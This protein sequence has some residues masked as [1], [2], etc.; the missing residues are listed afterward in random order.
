V[1]TADLIG[2]QLRP[3]DAYVYTG[4]ATLLDL[5]T[6]QEILADIADLSHQQRSAAIGQ[7][8]ES[9]EWV[10]GFTGEALRM[11]QRQQVTIGPDEPLKLLYV[12]N[13]RRAARR[14]ADAI[15][16]HM[17]DDFARLVVSDEPGALRTLRQATKER[18]PCAIVAVRMVTEGFDCPEV[19]TIAYASNWVAPLFVTQ[20]MARAM[21]ITATERAQKMILP[22]QFL[23]PDHAALRDAFAAALQPI[24]HVIKELEQI[25][26]P[27][28]DGI[29]GE[30][31]LPRFQLLD[32]S[33][34]ELR[35]ATVIGEADGDIPA[36]ELTEWE[37]ELGSLGVPLPFV[38][39]VA[40][41]AR[42]VRKWPRLYSAAEVDRPDVEV[43]DADPRAVN[44]VLRGRMSKI[45]NWMYVHL[46]HDGRWTNIKEFQYRANQAAGIDSRADATHDQLAT[47]IAWMTA[48]VYEHCEQR[49]EKAP[50]WLADQ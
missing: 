28:R 43:R 5:R 38:P 50:S 2:T 36:A 30:P 33:D 48:R 24:M 29:Y 40:L 32:L 17:N 14:A 25:E 19:S 10:K 11:L 21:R 42:R 18:Q 34:P 15:N 16:Q 35:N 27:T 41:A 23:I 9:R 4:Q 26:T 7:A 37:R 6:D 3:P 12:A 44:K 31:R 20:M 13:N 46:P 47:A 1:S 39:R 22:A 8:Y 49:N 45:S